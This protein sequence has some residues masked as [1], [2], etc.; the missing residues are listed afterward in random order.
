MST[1]R[2]LL[3]DSDKNFALQMTQ[4]CEALG[5]KL[6]VCTD[7]RQA[8]ETALN[9]NPDSV[10]LNVEIPYVGGYSICNKIR[11]NDKLK[12]VPVVLLSRTADERTFAQHKKLRTRADEYFSGS[13]DASA[14]LT[15]LRPHLASQSPGQPIESIQ[16]ITPSTNGT[17]ASS[18]SSSSSSSPTSSS[19]SSSSSSSGS[20]SPSSL[21]T[22]SF[23]ESSAS[24]SSSKVQKNGGRILLLLAIGFVVLIVFY[25]YVFVI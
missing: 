12:N 13:Y 17:S 4:R 15:K 2:I 24:Q 25:F 14:I 10:V 7:G 8:V 9:V 19:S 6:D 1:T 18:T 20:P 5:W 21:S 16:P 11:R 3:I 22:N 23:P